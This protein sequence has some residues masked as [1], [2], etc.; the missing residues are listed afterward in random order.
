MEW[1]EHWR[2]H[3]W[4]VWEDEGWFSRFAQPRLKGWGEMR[5]EQRMV[6][7]RTAD[8]ALSYYRIK[9]HDTGQIYLY[10]CW[11]RPQRNLFNRLQHLGG[12]GRL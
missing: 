10:P 8:K 2:P 9:R 7:P 6:L 1:A 4:L 5:L 3:V 12:A 11:R